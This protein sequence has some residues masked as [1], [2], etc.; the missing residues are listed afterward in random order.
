MKTVIAVV[1]V[2]DALVL[3]GMALHGGGGHDLP[4]TLLGSRP[5]LAI[6]VAAVAVAMVRFA[7][8]RTPLASGVAA[9]AAMAI[10]EKT[11]SMV[12]FSGHEHNVYFGGAVL[13]GW[14]FGRL[15]ARE[16]RWL[17]A[18]P[19]PLEDWL[20]QAG[21][22]AGMVVPYIDAGLSKITHSGPRWADAT[23]LQ[24]TILTNHPV[25]DASPLSAYARF[26]V[27]HAD[28]AR[29]LSVATL[30]IQ[31]GSIVYLLGPRARKVW[32]T[33]LITFHAN[34]TLTTLDIFYLQALI[35][36]FAFSYGWVR[37]DERPAAAIEVEPKSVKAVAIWF[38][39]RVVGAAAV[40]W[41]LWACG[42]V[43]SSR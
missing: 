21:A 25:D 32:G 42:I 22:L 28:V 38:C 8:D 9:L 10:L 33:L 13:A 31:L 6:L 35:L 20:A 2:L 26:I 5:C 17:T 37:L 7:R 29:A 43:G 36:L 30:I 4:W 18:A 24:S 12:K 19:A 39:V 34:V 41:F 11:E 1:V 27:Q 16:L 15:F 40:A 3:A 14:I 23:V